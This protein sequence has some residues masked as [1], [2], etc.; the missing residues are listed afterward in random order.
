M[1]KSIRYTISL[2]YTASLGAAFY[3]WKYQG[4]EGAGNLLGGWL[5]TLVALLVPAALGTTSK[6]YDPPEEL[7]LL[8]ILGWMRNGAIVFI[9]FWHG[10]H[11]LGGTYLVG[12][13]LFLAGVA[14]ARKRQEDTKAIAERI[15]KLFNMRSK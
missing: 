14:A 12:T 15:D 2:L 1:E 7:P 3:L 9:S 4:S 13:I 11:W 10:Y 6:T 5:W 8:S